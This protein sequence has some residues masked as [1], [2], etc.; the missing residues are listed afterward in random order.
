M[1]FRSK[2]GK[3]K[4]LAVTGSKR[5]SALPDVPTM[6]ES[7]VPGVEYNGWIGLFTTA[8]TSREIVQRLA[9]EVAKMSKSPDVTKYFPGWGVDPVANSPEQFG[10]I[11]RS[12][13]EKF[14]RVIREAK[15]PQVD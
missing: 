2:A 6:V 15:I 7:G 13:V 9:D 14:A 4:A 8:G 1:L 5:Q 12:E 10:A 3:F 11:F